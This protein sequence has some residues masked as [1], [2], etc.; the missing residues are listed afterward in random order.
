MAELRRKSISP[1]KLQTGLSKALSRARYASRYHNHRL[2]GKHPLRLLGTPKDIW[3]GSV[4]AGAHLLSGRFSMNGHLLQ[5]ENDPG[6]KWP[7]DGIW[8]SGFEGCV[9]DYLY[10]FS[11]L[12]DLNRAV[13]RVGARARSEEL[14]SGWIDHFDDWDEG[15]WR[16]DI[17]ARRLI[18][19]MTHA[20][21]IMDSDDLVLRSRILNSLAR[22]ARHLKQV[23]GHMAA[24]P[25]RLTA[26]TALIQTGLFLPYGEDRLKRGMSLLKKELDHEILPD[27][28]VLSRSPED[29]HNLLRDMV[30]LRASL[31]AMGHE[32]PGELEGV[33]ARMVPHL[34]MLLHGDGGL[35]LFNGSSEQNRDH[36]AATL[37]ASGITARAIRGGGE[38]GFSR[39]S[40][41]ETRLIQDVGPPADLGCSRKSH[42][43]TLSFEMSRGE[44]RLIVNCGSA[45]TG[46]GEL[47]KMSRSTA[48]HSTLTVGDKN[49]SEIRAD[50]L[51]GRGAERV[52]CER[53]EKDGHVM[54]HSGHDGYQPEFGL[55][56]RRLLYLDETGEDMRGEEVLEN[57]AVKSSSS[58]YDIRFHLHPDVMATLTGEGVE[59]RLGDIE[60]W[61]FRQKG[62]EITLEDSLYFGTPGRI[63][64]NQQIKLSGITDPHKTTVKWALQRRD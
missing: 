17:L 44:Q 50:G 35:A 64:K 15:A 58:S 24:G 28:G 21:L 60:Q 34:L 53:S 40:K 37:K 49:S 41:G 20:A 36:I 12:R 51:I 33:I 47:Y 1:G 8:Q 22:Q 46:D 25:D 2:K 43:G 23:V 31:K 45:V 3:S 19:W 14:V 6:G 26:I 13:D 55:L 42:A 59:L 32:V 56:H 5:S 54:L 4:A 30:V 27:G 48:A 61:I 62:A 11:W 39:L 10:S 29:Q 57:K 16:E 52:F 9:Y 38:S 63:R 18:N 7:G